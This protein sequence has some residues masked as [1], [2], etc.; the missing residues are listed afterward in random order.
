ML[1][2]ILGLLAFL[3]LFSFSTWEH[4]ANEDVHKKQ[5]H[6]KTATTWDSV[7]K[8]KFKESEE[9]LKGPLVPKVDTSKDDPDNSEPETKHKNSMYPEVYG[10]DLNLIPGH[11]DST[12]STN[13]SDYDFVPFSTFPDGPK[14]P[15]P[16]LGDFSPFLKT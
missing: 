14:A 11:K 4:M 9:R 8:K 7:H 16:F 2:L 1:Y 13:S 6:H 5:E 10:P 12:N 15:S 3:Y